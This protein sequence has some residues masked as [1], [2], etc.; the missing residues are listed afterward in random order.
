[1]TDSP[2]HICAFP[3]HLNA[4]DWLK[5]I[6]SRNFAGF[7]STW[8]KYEWLR[9]Q[10]MTNKFLKHIENRHWDYPLEVLGYLYGC[11]GLVSVG[12]SVPTSSLLTLPRW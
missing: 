1:M 9:R 4:A 2:A 10:L 8:Q 6:T 7:S 11:H 12:S 3:L 5:T